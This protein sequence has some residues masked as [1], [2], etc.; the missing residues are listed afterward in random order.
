[1]KNNSTPTPHDA[2]FKT[3]LSHPQTARFYG[4]ASAACATG[5][6]RPVNARLES[7]SF[8]EDDLRP[9]YSDLLYSLKTSKSDGYVHVLIEHQSSPDKYMAFRLM[10]Y[11]V[12]ARQRHLDARHKTLPLVIPVLF[13]QGKRSPILTP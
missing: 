11:A 2:V 1:M 5:D 8:V 12:A 6:L 10:R 13:Y 3:F 9:Y 4:A 7:G